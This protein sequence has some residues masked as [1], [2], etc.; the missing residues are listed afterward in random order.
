[1][2]STERSRWKHLRLAALCAKAGVFQTLFTKDVEALIKDKQETPTGASL[3]VAAAKGAC[4][5]ILDEL[6]GRSFRPNDEACEEAVLSGS[7]PCVQIFLNH[8]MSSH[9]AS[10]RFFAEA[11]LSLRTRE[12]FDFLIPNGLDLDDSARL[13]AVDLAERAL[14]NGAR[15]GRNT[16]ILAV[17]ARSPKVV[18][19][20]IGN[21]AKVDQP[22][23]AEAIARDCAEVLIPMLRREPELV[24]GAFEAAVN[25]HACSCVTAMCE[26]RDWVVFTDLHLQHSVCSKNPDMADVILWQDNQRGGKL[27]KEAAL[28]VAVDGGFRRCAEA[29]LKAG[30]VAGEDHSSGR[31]PT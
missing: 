9:P 18:E 24:S 8:G 7:I 19:L 1:M 28:T 26:E 12:M 29:L 25:S 23:C 14:A 30:A 31:G 15:L 4:P 17:K 2:L 27:D 3:V 13:G 22:C 16:L 20:L 6:M 5:E 11:A 21:G 10:L